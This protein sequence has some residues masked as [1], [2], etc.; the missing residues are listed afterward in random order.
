MK[1]CGSAL[2][3]RVLGGSPCLVPCFRWKCLFLTSVCT[4]ASCWLWGF[5]SKCMHCSCSLEALHTL[6]CSKTFEEKL[7]EESVQDEDQT[8]G[9]VVRW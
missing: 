2:R 4:V 1:N 5:E 7:A 8:D 3:R 6:L 9:S